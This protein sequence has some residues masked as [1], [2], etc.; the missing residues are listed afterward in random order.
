MGCWK[1]DSCPYFHDESMRKQL[2]EKRASKVCK[3]FCRG[4]CDQGAGCHFSHE[5]AL[6]AKASQNNKAA[7]KDVQVPSSTGKPAIGARTSTPIGMPLPETTKQPESAKTAEDKAKQIERT[8]HLNANSQSTT[9]APPTKESDQRSKG[10][11][12]KPAA[13]AS[14]VKRP[15]P[16]DSDKNNSSK[17]TSGPIVSI[18]PVKQARIHFK[19]EQSTTDYRF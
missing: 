12:L 10:A 2:A 13:T 7:A 3:F 5:C 19:A 17:D 6:A 1:G 9:T 14:Q 4:K 11:I 8:K 18:A 15:F 16:E